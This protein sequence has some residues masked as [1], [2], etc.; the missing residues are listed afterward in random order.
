LVVHIEGKD[1]FV[2]EEY[3][4]VAMVVVVV[5]TVV[6][7]KIAKVV[8]CYGHPLESEGQLVPVVI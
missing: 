5:D 2:V 6:A 4:V 1:K 8:D 7:G 3:L